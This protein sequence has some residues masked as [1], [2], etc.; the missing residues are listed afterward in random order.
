MKIRCISSGSYQEQPITGHLALW[1]PQQVCDI[2]ASDAAKLV[3]TGL[4]TYEDSSTYANQ[5]IDHAAEH[6]AMG[7]GYF[8]N[9]IAVKPSGVSVSNNAAAGNTWCIKLAAPGHFDAV[10]IIIYHSSTSATTVYQSIVAVTETASQ[11]SD[12][13]RW[14][15]V[16]GSTE[17][18]TLDG[19]DQY[20]WKSVKWSGSSTITSSA[21]T[22]S[23]PVINVSDWVPLSSVPRADGG[24]FPLVM[25]RNYVSG[26]TSSFTGA[27]SGMA[28]ATSANGG[29]I[30]QA[31]WGT[32]TGLYVTNPAANNPSGTQNDNVPTIGIQFRCR[33]QGIS[34]IGIGDSITQ[35]VVTTAD[36]FSSIGWRAA[37]AISALGMPCGYVNN[38]V[39][40]QAAD[41]Y[42]AAGLNAITKLGA[43]AVMI[44]AF[45]PNGPGSPYSTDASMRYGIQQQ[46]SLM[47]SL[48][49][50]ARGAKAWPFIATGVP[51][52]STNIPNA[53]Q[54][55][56][57]TVYR[58]G[59]LSMGKDVTPLNWDA[60]VTDGASPARILAGYQYDTT[61]PNEAAIALQAA[62]LVTALR[63]RFGV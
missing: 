53:S 46:A 42:T 3:A 33:K 19:V 22:A 17:Y 27:S 43:N 26:G 39:A 58:D 24:T 4:F 11:A 10:R 28:T 8:T 1:Q 18:S 2:E 63:A 47:Q 31:G 20:G 49:S 37:A 45:S 30:I 7:S 50:A 9:D 57:R 34:L 54:D 21:G 41:V 23:A 61:H 13:N 16:V 6:A 40:S 56:Y 29:F 38:G 32:D 51:C 12:I 55:S 48:I 60:L 59:I 44:Q 15:P 14:R 5:L 36:G 35:N 62:Q 52:N 25:V